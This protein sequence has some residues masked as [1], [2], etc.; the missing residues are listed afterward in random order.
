MCE[1]FCLTV[2][3]KGCQKFLSLSQSSGF[4]DL[5]SKIQ[6]CNDLRIAYEKMFQDKDVVSEMQTAF[7]K[8]V[9]RITKS[10]IT[11]RMNKPTVGNM[12]FKLLPPSDLSSGR[13]LQQLYAESCRSHFNTQT[14]SGRKN[15][16]TSKTAQ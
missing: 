15:E 1:G 2:T 6:K 13:I 12:G 3:A 11:N 4:D 14:L 9:T 16:N 10:P 7:N 5:L 8:D